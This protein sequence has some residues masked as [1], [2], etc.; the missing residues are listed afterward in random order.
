MREKLKIG[1]NMEMEGEK[2]DREKERREKRG[3][4][5][6]AV[7]LLVFVRPGSRDKRR[8]SAEALHLSLFV[9]S[10]LSYSLATHSSKP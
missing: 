4:K 7:S 8:F 9:L 10:I 5:D 3:E 6:T 2:I 1:G